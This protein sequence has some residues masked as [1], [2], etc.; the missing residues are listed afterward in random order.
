M[1]AARLPRHDPP[2]HPSGTFDVLLPGLSTL[3][4]KDSKLREL[5]IVGGRTIN[6]GHHPTSEP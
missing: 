6:G 3:D 4:E 2:N 1:P 5:L